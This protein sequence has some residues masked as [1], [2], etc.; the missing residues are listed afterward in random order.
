MISEMNRMWPIGTFELGQTV[1]SISDKIHRFSNRKECPYCSQTGVVEIKGKAFTC[2]GCDGKKNHIEIVEK[3]IGETR[4]IKGKVTFENKDEAKEQYM[5][6]KCF[7]GII[8]VKQDD[9]SVRYFASEKEAQ[10]A[11]DKYNKENFVREKI[12]KYEGKEFYD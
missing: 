2:P 5:T 6:D 4:K 12:K 8:I 1:Y 9:G 10:D 7:C 11:C 3:V